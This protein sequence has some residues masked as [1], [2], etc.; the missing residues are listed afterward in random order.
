LES[1]IPNPYLLPFLR[2]VIHG[3]DQG[4]GSIN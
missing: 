1:G 4:R 2:L 3:G